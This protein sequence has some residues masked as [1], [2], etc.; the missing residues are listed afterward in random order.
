MQSFDARTFAFVVRLWQERRD[1]PGSNPVWRG[2]I[3]D[4]QSGSRMYF[5]TLPELCEQ[6]QARSGMTDAPA[7]RRHRLRRWLRRWS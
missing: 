3:D 5:V 4:I 7:T 6:I 2:S 1:I